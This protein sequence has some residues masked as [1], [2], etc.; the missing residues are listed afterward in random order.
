MDCMQMP[1]QHARKQQKKIRLKNT[2]TTAFDLCVGG[3]V[4]KILPGIM[5][6]PGVLPTPTRGASWGAPPTSVAP[7]IFIA[8]TDAAC[9]ADK[10]RLE[11]GGAAASTTAVPGVGG[12]AVTAV[13]GAAVPGAAATG[14][15]GAATPATAAPCA[16]LQAQFTRQPAFFQYPSGVP[17]SAPQFLLLSMEEHSTLFQAPP[18]A[19]PG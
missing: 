12:A 6:G 15:G 9:P 18:L 2:L 14:L 13:G 8:G 19:F 5:P 4:V 11:M 16:C 1:T 3:G 17:P 10:P 7:E